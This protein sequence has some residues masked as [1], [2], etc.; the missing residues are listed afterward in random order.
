MKKKTELFQRLRSSLEEG[1]PF[2]KGEATRRYHLFVIGKPFTD[3]WWAGNLSKGVITAGYRNAI[4]DQGY[5]F[6]HDMD[7]HDWVIAYA[8]G[9]GAVGAGRVGGQET[10]QLLRR[11]IAPSRHRQVRSVT[12]I[13][14]VEKLNEAVPF[15]QLRLGFAPRHGKTEF[16]DRKNAGRIIRLLAS[17]SSSEGAPPTHEAVDIEPPDRIPTTTYRILRDTIKSRTVKE[18]HQFKCQVCGKTIQLPDGSRYAE[19]HHVQPLGGE[20][21]GPDI[22]SNILCVCPNHHAELDM[23]VLRIKLSALRSANGHVVDP[24]YVEYHN[25]VIFNK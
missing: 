8:K 24:K 7:K 1:I 14:Y 20:H 3:E 9:Y 11:A 10:Y 13:H 16:T 21:K 22:V 5:R 25:R 4:G 17:K 18:L 19:G 15:R 6:L 12:W 23:G 2:A